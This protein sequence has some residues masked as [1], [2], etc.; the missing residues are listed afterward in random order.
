M[1]ATRRPPR[2]WSPRRRHGSRTSAP[3]A[4][5]SRIGGAVTCCWSI[6]REAEERRS[7]APSAGA[8][9]A[10]RG[11]LEFYA[12]PTSAYHR[13]GVRPRRRTILYCASGGRS[14]LAAET[15][16]H[17]AT[18]G[19]LTSTAVSRRGGKPVIVVTGRS[20]TDRFAI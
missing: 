9:H 2:I 18:P 4:V 3:E 12:D 5:G 17:S 16:Q 11:M 10:P 1:S 6:V 19:S 8:I 13:P 15:L 7:T 14:A 20:N